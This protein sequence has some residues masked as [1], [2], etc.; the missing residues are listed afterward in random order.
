MI[1][2]AIICIFFNNFAN[3]NVD[4][5]KKRSFWIDMAKGYGIILVLIGHVDMPYM[6]DT[7]YAFHIPLF[8]FL[9][10]YC[11]NIKS[12]FN[13]FIRSKIKR[14]L[15]PYVC[16]CIPIIFANMFFIGD[17][18]CSYL[19]CEVE[20]F[21]VQERFTTLWFISCLLLVNSL[22]YPIVRYCKSSKQTVFFV[23]M[24]TLIGIILWRKG[25]LVLP[26]NI[27][28]SFVVLPFFYVGFLLK[29]KIKEEAFKG[30]KKLIT[31]LG[32]LLLVIII[33]ILNEKNISLSGTKVDIFYSNFNIEWLSYVI[34][35]LGIIMVT[36]LS[37]C[38]NNS[39][40]MYIGR[41]SMIFF[42]WHQSIVFP[43]L[44]L[45]YWKT[46]ISQ[47]AIYH[48]TTFF[49]W[50]SILMAIVILSLLNEV[51]INSRIKF[52]LGQ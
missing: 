26:W 20:G 4:T 39:F 31:Y 8:F 51:V 21:V 41:N 25:V 7:L 46:G 49:K 12:D 42:A 24:L 13:S 2:I 1:L 27:D 3:M 9:S 29:G 11:F 17:F 48:D 36:I 45:I 34:A 16:L 19:I 43:F 52:I 33:Y 35:F 18:S 32:V 28:A 6:T 30:Q 50:F 15:I 14:L 40:L 10:G 44:S 5:D 23:L 22:M 38:I 37:L 47:L